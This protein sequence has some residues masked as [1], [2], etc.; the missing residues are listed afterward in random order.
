MNDPSP[1]TDDV[2][3][4]PADRR[5]G[6]RRQLRFVVAATL[7][8]STYVFLWT[9]GTG[10]VLGD[11]ACH[12]RRAV[13]CFEMPW[14]DIRA[15]YDTAYPAEGRGSIL[16]WDSCLWHLGLAVIWKVLGSASFLAAQL[17]HTVFLTML[18]VFTYLCGRELWG[19]RGG[20][21]AWALVLSIPMN[22]LFGMTFYMEV[23]V[24][25]FAAVA[26]YCLLRRRAVLMGL[27]MAAMFLTKAPSSAVLIPPL[28]CASLLVMG[29]SWRQRLGRTLLAA[30]VMGL[31]M[32]PDMMWRQSHFGQPVLF[33]YS[34][35]SGH[36]YPPE[37]HRDIITLPFPKQTA[38]AVG[39]GNPVNLVKMFGLPGLLAVAGALVVTIVGLL[40][41]LFHLWRCLRGK[42]IPAVW[43]QLPE[44]VP[45]PV[46]VLGV[47]LL[48]Y[49]IA[50]LV[51]LQGAYDVR[52]LQPITLPAC[53]LL[54]GELS[55]LSLWPSKGRSRWIRKA[56]VMVL[57]LA[58]AG[59]FLAVPPVV[60]TKY[61]WLPDSILQAFQWIRDETP[62]SARFLY[63]EENLTTLTGRPFFWYAVWPR[64]LFTSTDEQQARM[65]TFVGIDYI[66]I[67]P[68]RRGPPVDIEVEPT[69]YPSDWIASLEGRPY[70]TRVYPENYDGDSTGRFLIYRV[71]RHRM[72]VEWR[73]TTV[74]GERAPVQINPSP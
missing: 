29:D 53:L 22:L 69:G 11:E 23:P 19:H 54:A 49:L 14:P 28:L 17:Y 21:W 44:A 48:C 46:L 25:A 65:L 20:L 34:T 62:P 52:Y 45:R 26:I 74:M 24:L 8:V 33:R 36:F 47:P 57:V 56:A 60:A 37:I 58:M 31:A 40:R 32:V 7:A 39:A 63:V 72:P 66:A 6:Y 1:L 68:T 30:V 51:M 35:D 59:Q 43:R 10:P 4:D 38:V 27:S 3:L 64:Y 71:D 13:N 9:L 73:S 18:G 67:H 70:L 50:Y 42:W 55:R 41:G 61:R 12:Y 5:A 15:T 2:A 16:Y